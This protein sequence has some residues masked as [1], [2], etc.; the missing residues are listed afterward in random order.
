MDVAVERVLQARANGERV[1]IFGDYDVD[2][3]S[4]TA[5]LMRFFKIIGIPVSSRIPHRTKDGY[6]MKSYFFDELATKQVKLVISVDCGTRDIEVIQ[7]AKKLG[8]DV[9]V[10]DHH[11]IPEFIPEEAIAIISPKLPGTPYP[12]TGLSGSG[13]AFKLLSAV[14]SRIYPKREEYEEILTSFI[15]FAALGT[16]ADMMPLVGENRTIVKLGLAQLANSRSPGLRELIAGKSLLSADIIGFHIGPRIN[17]AGRMESA[18][19]ALRA[20][21]CGDEQVAALLAEIEVLNGLR[22]GSTEKFMEEALEVVDPREPVIFFVSDSID[23]G[24]IGLVA[25]RLAE[26]FSK[27]AIVCAHDADKVFGSARSP[28]SYDITAALTRVSE[29]FIAFGGHAQAAGFTLK[30]EN[31]EAFRA[32]LGTDRTEFLAKEAL[33]AGES[34]IPEESIVEETSKKSRGKEFL[35]ETIL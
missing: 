11:A 24:V 22:K 34:G 18:D 15:D 33:A 20:L 1:V 8:I 3:V 5:M 31:F 16:V 12:F 32:A 25:G 4:S 2:G 26:R 35:I 28:A 7:A 17:A 23:H 21:I 10:T 30:P 19:T 14:A 9:I 27:P 29:Y 13:V 6:G